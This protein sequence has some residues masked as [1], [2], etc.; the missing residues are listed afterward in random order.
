MPLLKS[1]GSW[2]SERLFKPFTNKVL[3][4]FEKNIIQPAIRLIEVPI[5]TSINIGKGIEGASEVWAKR[6]GSLTNDTISAVDNVETGLGNL[7]KV[8]LVPIAAVLGGLY[9]FKR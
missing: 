9:L 7:F 1:L 5:K 2:F 4:P 3:Q 6:A 8:P